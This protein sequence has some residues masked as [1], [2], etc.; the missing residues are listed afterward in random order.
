MHNDTK[1]AIAIIQT[2]RPYP[3][4]EPIPEEKQEWSYLAFDSGPGGSGDVIFSP[5]DPYRI[6]FGNIESAETYWNSQ[7]NNIRD[8]WELFDPNS[9]CIREFST[10]LAKNNK[11][12]NRKRLYRLL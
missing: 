3:W 2:K 4:M 1:Y 8:N 12:L 11:L 6:Y 5:F 7:K 10:S 9:I